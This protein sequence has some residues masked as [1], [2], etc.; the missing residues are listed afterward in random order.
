MSSEGL[1]IPTL[2]TIILATSRKNVEQSVGRI[3]RKQDG[4]EIDP[5][6]IDIVDNLKQFKNQGN[7]RKRH[8]KKITG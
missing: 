2:N 7:I 1:D 4:Y 8:Y 5:L 6:I 3:L